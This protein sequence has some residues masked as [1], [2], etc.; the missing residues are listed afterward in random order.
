MLFNP[1]I[2]KKV[3]EIIFYQKENDTNHPGLYFNNAL[4][5]RQSVQKHLGFFLDEKLSF[6]EHTDVKIKKVTVGVNLKA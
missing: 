3:Q 5:Q 2:T 4:I 1:D 6:F